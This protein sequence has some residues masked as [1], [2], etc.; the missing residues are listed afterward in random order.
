MPDGAAAAGA[1]GSAP[2][3]AP[4]ASDAAAAFQAALRRDA[5][6]NP[7]EMPAPPRIAVS[8]DPDAPHG[9][10]EDGAAL[11]PYGVKADGRPRIKP[12]GPGR[13][14]RSPDDR[15]NETRAAASSPSSSGSKAAAV[16]YRDDLA[17]LGMSVW[18]AGSTLPATRPY[19]ALFKQ[20]M[21]GM[22]EAWNEAAQ[23]NATV[24][25]YVEKLAGEGSWSWVIKVAIT[26]TPFVLGCWELARPM[27]EKTPDQAKAKAARN[28]RKQTLAT[29]AETELREYIERQI[30]ELMGD[31]ALE[32]ARAERDSLA[33]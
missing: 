18:L 10:G 5:V 29:Q 12:A 31:A 20:S 4:P 28:E 26:T 32:A 1:P 15:P 30:A 3:P 17:G 11:A 27:S 33:A 6:A 23:H 24:R 9:R 22:V 21:P 13:G 25:G 8:A 14:N 19:A 2:A 16:D 7:P